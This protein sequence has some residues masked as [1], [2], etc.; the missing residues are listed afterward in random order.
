[1]HR[2]P[3]GS[4]D[5]RGPMPLLV[6][7]P[8]SFSP[9][10]DAISRTAFAEPHPAAPNT[11]H[12]HVHVSAHTHTHTHHITQTGHHCARAAHFL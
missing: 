7:N 5:S 1:M 11:F 4:I 12:V 2:L 3:V 8:C 10:Q 6:C 9:A